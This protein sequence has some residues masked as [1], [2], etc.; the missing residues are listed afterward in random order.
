MKPT[1]TIACERDL[2]PERYRAYNRQATT[3]QDVDS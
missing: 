1:N 3:L 2:Y